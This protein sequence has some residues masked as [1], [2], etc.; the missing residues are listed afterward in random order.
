MFRFSSIVNI[1]YPFLVTEYA[2]H[3]VDF[4]RDLPGNLADSYDAITTVSGDGLF[5]EMINGI[6]ARNDWKTARNIPIGKRNLLL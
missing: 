4:I 1:Y 2:G 6:L 5:H 3:A